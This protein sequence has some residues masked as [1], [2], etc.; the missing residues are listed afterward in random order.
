M[1]RG[2]R[3]G[4]WAFVTAAAALVVAGAAAPPWLPPGPRLALTGAYDLLCHQLPARSPHVHGVALALCWRCLGVA[5]GVLVGAALSVAWPPRVRAGVSRWTRVALIGT[6]ALLAGLHMVLAWV[7]AHVPGTRSAITAHPTC[8]VRDGVVLEEAM[9]DQR[10]TLEEVR[11]AVRQTGKGDLAE[12][13]FV[14]LE[15]DGTLSVIGVGQVG[16]GSALVDVRGAQ[17]A[18]PKG[19]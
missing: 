18:G 10:L 7:S 13:A 17:V 1:T 16:S 19:G 4:G 14:V 5:A 11:Q 8:V 3:W 2:V 15:S 9:R 12:V 6:L